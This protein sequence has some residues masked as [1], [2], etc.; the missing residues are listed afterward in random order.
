[1]L[2]VVVNIVWFFFKFNSHSLFDLLF[3]IA[4]RNV[5]FCW[6]F[7]GLMDSLKRG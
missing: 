1:M 5:V 4:E 2:V 7:C 3:F 6:L